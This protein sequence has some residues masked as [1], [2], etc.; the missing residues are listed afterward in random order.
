MADLQQVAPQRGNVFV[1]FTRR[2]AHDRAGF[3][4]HVLGIDLQEWQRE[5]L[6]YLD[7]GG[8]RL[9]IRS[10]HG[11][12]KS[13]LLAWIIL[14]FVLT[15][16]PS[17]CVAT[18]N[19]GSQLFD[20][21]A[22]ETKMWLRKLE[23]TIPAFK[24]L[25]TAQN[26]RIELAAAPESAF[27]TYRTSRLENP[28]ALQGVHSEN[29]LLIADE[30][31]G[32]PDQVFEAAGGSMSSPG[33]IAVLAGNP[34]RPSGYFFLTQTRLTAHWRVIHVP[35][36][37]STI[38]SQDYAAEMAEAHG[39]ESNVY[40]VRVLGEFPVDEEDTLIPLSLVQDAVGR[41]VD[42]ATPGAPEIWGVDVARFGEDSSA[43][44]KRR[45]NTLL[46]PIKVFRQ[47]DT[48]QLTGAIV[49][50]YNALP[51]LQRPTEICVDVI[52][53]GA[54]VVDRLRELDLPVLGV[55]VAESAT[56]QNQ[57]AHRL[58]DEL[59]LAAK[60]WLLARDCRLPDDPNL[61]AELATPRVRFTSAGK[62][63]V[64]SKDEA[65]ARG[66]KS[67]DRADAFCLTFAALAARVSG[68]GHARAKSWSEPL[69]R[70]VGG[71]V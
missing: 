1:D 20:V 39:Q 26:D 43:L 62:L 18:A 68:Y 32:I 15:R 6:L 38:A 2:F 40:R 52:G 13:A 60:T 30:A 21:L 45:A 33:A 56:F 49:A 37:R 14:H 57:G 5:A 10:G 27:A 47:Y 25:L 70:N 22:A 36:S 65:K 67:P 24:G 28:E 64:E 12:G 53:I 23:Q 35:I 58:R 54:G 9:T 3:C 17:K 50:E 48:M 41:D 34:T 29:V 44:A 63:R 8:A 19:T 46:E 16:Y 69:R 55:N 51:P 42:L 11:V 66:I 59:W 31:S 4:T 61:V 7:E 71:I